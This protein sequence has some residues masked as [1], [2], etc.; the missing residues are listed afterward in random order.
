[1]EREC[2]LFC[3]VVNSPCHSPTRFAIFFTSAGGAFC[4]HVCAFAFDRK[5]SK[6]RITGIVRIVLMFV[7]RWHEGENSFIV[8]LLP[9]RRG[10]AKNRQEKTMSSLRL[11]VSA[12]KI[13]I[14]TPLPVIPNGQCIKHY[15]QAQHGQ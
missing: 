6:T 5:A 12:V 13:K 1:M 9:Q 8:H 4:V 2:V 15:P 11:S 14:L 7:L 3:S 10:G